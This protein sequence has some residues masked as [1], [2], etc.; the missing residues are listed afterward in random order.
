M[1]HTLILNLVKR[2]IKIVF[3]LLKNRTM[4]ILKKRNSVSNKSHQSRDTLSTWKVSVNLGELMTFAATDCYRYSY[5]TSFL[6]YLLI[7]L[8]LNLKL[9]KNARIR[10]E[11]GLFVN[12]P[13][14]CVITRNQWNGLWSA[15]SHFNSG[16]S[17]HCLHRNWPLACL[18][19]C[20]DSC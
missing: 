15:V 18:Y 20:M 10:H 8:K 12:N 19:I 2:H 6:E 11:N 13:V 7:F 3:I 17:P 14:R 9:K 16:T 5:W 1:R 4:R